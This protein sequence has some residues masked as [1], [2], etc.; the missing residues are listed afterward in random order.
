[1]LP[2]PFGRIV[3]NTHGSAAFGRWLFFGVS[4]L[5]KNRRL[6]REAREI[7]AAHTEDL[8]TYVS[9]DLKDD[10]AEPTVDEWLH[11]NEMGTE[12]VLKRFGTP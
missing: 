1:M 9:I 6:G 12:N 11:R 5:L 3:A 4:T 8:Q 2:R 10:D 7:V